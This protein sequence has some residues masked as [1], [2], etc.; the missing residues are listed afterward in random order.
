MKRYDIDLSLSMFCDACLSTT[1]LS[2]MEHD[3][4][5]STVTVECDLNLYCIFCHE[6]PTKDVFLGLFTSL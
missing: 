4:D 3:L 2:D 1:M 6:V 5:D